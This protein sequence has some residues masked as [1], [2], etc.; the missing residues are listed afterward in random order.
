MKNLLRLVVGALMVT[1]L[2]APLSPVY[3]QDQNSQ[4]AGQWRCQYSMQPFNKDPMSTHYWE[5]DIALQPDTTYRMQGFY[6]S[7]ALGFQ[8]SIYG[9]GQWGMTNEGNVSVQGQIYRQD[10][11]W[12]PFQMLVKPANPS[13]LYLQFQGNTHFTNIV[14]QR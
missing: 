10:Q 1:G 6:Y 13:S 14:C 12:E 11:G 4:Y 5:F 9:E 8:V 7:P 3:A 2:I